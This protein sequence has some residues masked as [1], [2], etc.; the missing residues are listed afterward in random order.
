MEAFAARAGYVGPWGGV[1]QVKGWVRRRVVGFFSW[2]RSRG[3]GV[4][5]GFVFL[6]YMNERDV[7]V[8]KCDVSPVSARF[9]VLAVGMKVLL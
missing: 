6:V 9:A 4:G 1:A 5:L 3:G 7:K 8:V 2:E